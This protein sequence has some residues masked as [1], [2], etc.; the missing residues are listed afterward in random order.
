MPSYSKHAWVPWEQLAESTRSALWFSLW[1]N[2]ELLIWGRD[3]FLQWNSTPK[4]S[5]KTSCSSVLF[6]IFCKDKKDS[7]P[8]VC[9]VHLRKDRV[10]ARAVLCVG[11][12][13]Q[14]GQG[15]NSCYQSHLRVSEMSGTH[16]YSLGFNY[17]PSQRGAEWISKSNAI[18]IYIYV[19]VSVC[20]FMYVVWELR[21]HLLPAYSTSLLI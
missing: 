15:W 21:F 16:K 12:P 2:G 18:Y 7:L 14:T 11:L 20:L 10:P 9:A 17:L 1:M 6:L 8:S 3:F 13:R 4:L 5:L 19:Y